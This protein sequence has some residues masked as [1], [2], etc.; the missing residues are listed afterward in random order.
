LG[1]VGTS[2]GDLCGFGSWGNSNNYHKRSLVNYWLKRGKS[3]LQEAPDK[4]IEGLL[5][6]GSREST[7]ISTHKRMA[8]VTT[9]GA[10]VKSCVESPKKNNKQELQGAKK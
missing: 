3:Y 5:A 9:W 7:N 2:G 8:R 6:L 10:Q 4:P 1:G